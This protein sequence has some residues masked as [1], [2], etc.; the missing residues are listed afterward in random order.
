MKMRGSG[1]G[2]HLMRECFGLVDLEWAKSMCTEEWAIF[3]HA[4]YVDPAVV[5]R[6]RP[7]T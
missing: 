5:G 3:D 6:Q 2:D 1:Y 4:P 7:V